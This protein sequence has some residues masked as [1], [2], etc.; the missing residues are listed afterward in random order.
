M[1][2]ELHG[3]IDLRKNGNYEESNKLLKKL[4][5]DFPENASVNYQCAWSFDLLGEEA[6][7]A[8]FYEKAI[9][10]GLPSEEMEGAILGLGSTYRTLGEYEKS[11]STLRKGI[12]LFPENRAIQVFYSMTL[13]NLNENSRAMELILKCLTDTTTDSKI[14]GYKKAIDFYSDK[15]D[16]VWK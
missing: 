9:D 8:P 15:L 11:K 6:K 14:L 12:K 16:Q 7:A 1:E 13:Y 2:K 3:A 5:N 4:T 10:L